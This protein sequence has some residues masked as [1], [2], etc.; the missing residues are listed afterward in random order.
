MVDNQHNYYKT[1]PDRGRQNGPRGVVL[2]GG[3]PGSNN[4]KRTS[5]RSADRRRQTSDF[6]LSSLGPLETQ[7]HAGGNVY[8]FFR[9][10]VEDFCDD[11]SGG[12]DTT[13][14]LGLGQLEHGLGR[15]LP[16]A[17]R[18]GVW[19]YVAA[20]C[21]RLIGDPN[22]MPVIKRCDKFRGI[23][24]IDVDPYIP[25]ASGQQWYINRNQFFRQIRNFRFDLTDMPEST[26]DEDQEL[27]PT[28]IHWQVS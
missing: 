7:P 8:Q 25:G 2:R 10:V 17:M 15:R 18:R 21:H 13:E 24:L 28:G 9:N 14:T 27:V 20:G 4:T 26:A 6:W 16:D 1:A 5:F 3:Y 22:D 11:N 12:T 23:A 19:Q